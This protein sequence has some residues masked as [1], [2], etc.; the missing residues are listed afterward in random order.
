MAFNGNSFVQDVPKSTKPVKTLTLFSYEGGLDN[1]SSQQ[2]TKNEC[3]TNVLNMVYLEDGLIQKR[4]GTNKYRPET[5]NAAIT[6]IDVFHSED[7]DKFVVGTGNAVYID[8]TKII[9]TTGTISGVTV[10]NRYMFVD[11]KSLYSYEKKDNTWKTYKIVTPT[12]LEDE[13]AA[14]AKKGEKAITVKDGSKFK[15]GQWVQIG[16][17]TVDDKGLV[18]DVPPPQTLKVL[19]VS[20]NTVTFGEEK[21]I[22]AV[23]TTTTTRTT[24][25]SRNETVADTNTGDDEA[26]ITTT[27]LS[28][29]YGS[30]NKVKTKTESTRLTGTANTTSTVIGTGVTAVYVKNTKTGEDDVEIEYQRLDYDYKMGTPT[31]IFPESELYKYVGEWKTDE[32]LN[33]KWYEPCVHELRHA[34]FGVNVVPPEP[35][36]ICLNKGRVIITCGGSEANIIYMSEVNNMYYFPVSTGLALPNNGDKVNGM[37]VF[38]DSLVLT[39]KSDVYVVYGSSNNPD[40]DDVFTMK[41]VTTHTGCANGDTLKAVH[42]YLFYLGSDGVVYRMHTTNT[43][44]RLLATS[45]VSQTVDLLKAPISRTV[46]QIQDACATFNN[47]NYYL[48]IGDIVL[49]YSYRFMAWT[50]FD[51]LNA[52]YMYNIDDEIIWAKENRIMHFDKNTFLDEGIDF[53]CFWES[54]LFDLNLPVNYKYFKYISL[55]FDCYEHFDS[56]AKLLFEIDYEEVTLNHIF[57][58]A[59]SR[60]GVAKWGSDRFVKKNISKSLPI[61]VGRRGRLVKIKVHNGNFV[62]K[63]FDTLLEMESAAAINEEVVYVKENKTHYKRQLDIGTNVFFWQVLGNEEINQP[64]KLYNIEIEYSLRGRR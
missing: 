3:A 2:T 42:N 56:T 28:G 52:N 10:S 16:K 26:I 35:K 41:K 49:V 57:K 15:K 25:N 27:K 39:R 51:R 37:V 33:T 46:S 11:G 48:S 20:G 9:D 55:V 7:G 19:E 44:I 14:D 22:D 64:I 13:L 54:K 40:Y 8:G 60:W 45:V 38:H 12:N 30:D 18:S 59:I 4:Y 1:V 53:N 23:E 24:D 5:Y 36:T 63:Q 32:V 58:N 6:Y 43:D 21:K 31:I 34:Y 50:V 29:D 47:E 62:N 61:Y 17:R